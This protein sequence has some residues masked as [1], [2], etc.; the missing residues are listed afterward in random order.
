LVGAYRGSDLAD[1]HPLRDVLSLLRR[2]GLVE[3]MALNGLE[4]ADVQAITEVLAGRFISHDG[5]ALTTMLLEE[6]GGNPLF[7]L[8]ILRHL[9]ES[10]VIVE[11]DG[12]WHVVGTLGAVAIPESVRDVINRRVSRLGPD[13][14]RVLTTAALVGRDFDIDLL[15]GVLGDDEDTVLAVLEAACGARLTVEHP[16]VPG[17]FS[18]AHVL[19]LHALADQVGPTRRSQVHRRVAQALEDLYGTDPGSRLPQLALHWLTAVGADRERAVHYARLAGDQALAQLAPDHAADWYRKAL[20]LMPEGGP[21]PAT[22]CDLLISLG[23][24]L[25]DAGD[26]ASR[27]VL[28]HAAGLALDVGDGARLARAALANTRG[29]VSSA[30]EV[31]VER[32]AVLESALDLVGSEDSGDRARLLALLAME[33][34]FDSDWERRLA[35]ADESLAV[36]RRVDDPLTLVHVLNVYADAVWMP[37]TLDRRLAVTAEHE[38]LAERLGDP[39]QRA[40]AALRRS[41]V[42][43][44]AADIDAVD[45]HMTR[46][47]SLADVHPYLR[48]NAVC[49]WPHRLLLGG[50]IDDAEAKVQ[51]A[52][53]VGQAAE[54]PDAFQVMAAQLVMVRWDQGRLPELEPLLAQVTADNPGIP[55]FR[56]LFELALCEADRLDD[57]R[58]HFAEDA[59]VAFDHV[60]CNPLWLATIAQ[61]AEVCT[62]LS[63]ST[64]AA[65]LYEL[66]APWRDQMIFTG[67]SVCGAVAHYLGQLAHVM[68][69]LDDGDRDFGQATA[70]YERMSAVNFLARTRLSRGRLLLDRDGPGDRDRATELLQQAH[71]T[72]AAVGMATIERRCRELVGVAPTPD[73]R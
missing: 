25:R 62:A 56:S 53:E 19:V 21:D 42:A 71:G 59:A 70:I 64:A 3:Q 34:L 61:F 40:F 58:L 43:W 1:G 66:L 29:G 54:S 2:D 31:D 46:F 22:R 35:L 7:V 10:G 8:E 17:S 38:D 24:A 69:R 20:E 50:R 13:A 27:R 15:A 57:A 4:Q 72:A 52:F 49:Q 30:G 33:L 32:V 41:R 5:A 23:T 44:E 36:A 11:Q 37:H 39:V 68:G 51:E 45:R 12:S 14:Q 48:W 6:T 18:F 73:A 65:V 47:S 55:G 26:G 28:L 60:Q 16:E 63:D 67:V 9:T